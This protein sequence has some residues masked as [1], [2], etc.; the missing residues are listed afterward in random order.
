MLAENNTAAG[1][2]SSRCPRPDSIYIGNIGLGLIA[3]LIAGQKL[4]WI[5]LIRADER[6]AMDILA[7]I[8]HRTEIK[9][10]KIAI[11]L[12]QLRRQTILLTPSTPRSWHQSRHQYAERAKHHNQQNSQPGPR[13][14][15][16]PTEPSHNSK[17]H[18]ALLSSCY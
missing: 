9:H 5:L 2:L 18:L 4:A 1:T 8:L 3:N 16:T 7:P 6:H 10:T 14:I 17:S 13:N 15:R 12:R 11:L